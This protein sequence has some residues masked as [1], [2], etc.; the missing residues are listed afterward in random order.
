MADKVVT[1]EIDST[2]V[3]GRD[4]FIT[5]GG[6]F[7][8]GGA[9]IDL[10][11]NTGVGGKAWF[12]FEHAI[13]KYYRC[14][15]G[16]NPVTETWD[17]ALKGAVLT[18]M[19]ETDITQ[20]MTLRIRAELSRNPEAPTST[21]DLAA[22]TLTTKYVDWALTPAGVTVGVALV[23]DDLAD[24]IN[25]VLE[26][27]PPD[28]RSANLLLHVTVQ[29]AAGDTLLGVESGEADDQ[30]SLAL[31]THPILNIWRGDAIAQDA[32]IT[33]TIDTAG[34]GELYAIDFHEGRA[35]YTGITGDD[36][37]EIA[38]ALGAAIEDLGIGT[39]EVSTNEIT[40]TSDTPGVPIHYTVVE[41][42]GNNLMTV[43]VVN[44]G[45]G[46]NWANEP[47]N[48]SLAR[49]LSTHDVVAF[50]S[51]DSDCLYGLVHVAAVSTVA[52]NDINLTG[53]ADFVVGQI[54]RLVSDGDLPQPAS[55][56][57]TEETDL[58]ITE[59]DTA[60]NQIQVSLTRGGSDI[61]WSTQGT[62]NI[63]VAVQ[64][65]H[66]RKHQAYSGAIGLGPRDDE[67][68]YDGRPRYLAVGFLDPITNTPNCEIGIGDGGGSGRCNLDGGP[69]QIDA[70]IA[71]TGGSPDDTP[72]CNL[73]SEH[74]DF[75]M[76]I[77]AGD[78]GLAPMEGDHSVFSRLQVFGGS[79]TLGNDVEPS[80]DAVIETYGTGELNGGEMVADRVTI[81]NRG[82]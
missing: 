22:R 42:T 50:E 27:F 28:G 18:L 56:T 69:T 44:T 36:T 80:E 76:V 40:L 62:G 4:G 61:S 33:I 67:G 78:V 79:L 24:I 32:E 45:T 21:A 25:E 59:V 8:P 73:K 19:A 38:T 65:R 66:L 41:T 7:T 48:W 10:E 29:T 54:V 20:N 5:P 63:Y 37:S 17:T 51:G 26:N 39:V 16:Y 71:D 57:L 13:D 60:N 35:E 30:P 74:A 3:E 77:L 12:L 81:R 75:R 68:R 43:E 9:A 31:R 64:L 70:L 72:A 58:Y 53:A 34:V 14:G 6:T 2:I 46:P 49:P 47:L 15:T 55:P 11:W 52:T 1:L 23:S 82:T